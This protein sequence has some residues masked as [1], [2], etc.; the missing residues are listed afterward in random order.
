MSFIYVLICFYSF[1]KL[2]PQ[3]QNPQNKTMKMGRWYASTENKTRFRI[4]VLVK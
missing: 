2:V 1:S 3:Q 4:K